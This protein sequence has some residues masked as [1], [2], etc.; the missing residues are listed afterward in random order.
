MDGRGA[1]VWMSGH[2]I[3]DAAG[4]PTRHAVLAGHGGGGPGYSSGVLTGHIR[5]RL[6]MAAALANTDAPDPRRRM[7]A[8]MLEAAWTD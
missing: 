5:G 7:A 6:A 3:P 8:A 1:K 2:D 4:H